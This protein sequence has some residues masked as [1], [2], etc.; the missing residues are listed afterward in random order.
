[1]KFYEDVAQNQ[2]CSEAM[3]AFLAFAKENKRRKELL[4]RVRR[5]NITEM[6]LEPITDLKRSDYLI[7]V[8]LDQDTSYLAILG[9]AMEMEERA[10][11]FYRES[12]R[13]AKYLLAEVS[14]TFEK[15]ARERANH[16]LKLKSLHDNALRPRDARS[17]IA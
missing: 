2:K 12:A 5:E 3:E 6:I 16:E 8:K 17:H 10:H 14:R 1:M 15:I 9:L 13:K 11:R 4:E 7:E